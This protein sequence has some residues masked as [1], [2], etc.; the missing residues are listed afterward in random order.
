MCGLPVDDTCDLCW[1]FRVVK[2]VFAV[3]IMVPKDGN[4]DR[5][6]IG[7]YARGKLEEI[8]Q[9]QLLLWHGLLR[10]DLRLLTYEQMGGIL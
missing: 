9:R 1:I 6:I 2:D 7:V 3:Q 5:V 8:F 4:G 10:K